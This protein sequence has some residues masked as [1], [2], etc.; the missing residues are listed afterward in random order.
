MKLYPLVAAIVAASSFAPALA[1]EPFVYQGRLNDGAQAAEGVYDIRVDYYTAP[2]G[3]TPSLTQLVEDVTVEDGV[4]SVELPFP[5]SPAARWV[6]IGVRPGTSVAAHTTLNPRQFIAAGPFASYALNAPWVLNGTTMSYGDG[7]DVVLINRTVRI[8]SEYFGIGADTS[9]FGGMYI[10]TTSSEGLPFYGYSAGGDVDAYHFFEGA[11][12]SLRLSMPEGEAIVVESN[13]DTAVKGTLTA[14]SFAYAAPRELVYSVSLASFK[15]A[16]MS[17]D[18]V[19][20]VAGGFSGLAYIN[21]PNG[22]QLM[23]APVNLPDGARITRITAKL[24]DGSS[25][26]Q[27]QAQLR[28]LVV[29]TGEYSSL[30]FVGTS[31]AEFFSGTRSSNIPPLNAVVN[32]ASSSYEILLFAGGGWSTTPGSI[33]VGYV[34]ITYTVDQPD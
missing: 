22:N 17:V 10:S 20:Y 24:N 1:S 15:P 4:F 11:T 7:N 2:S 30:G 31:M 12:G 14:E 3:G 23:V 27:I 6:G 33:S 25:S 16:E 34:G 32:N 21:E 28:R 29:S 5:P 18:F 8:G 13:G 9:S 26:R 19:R